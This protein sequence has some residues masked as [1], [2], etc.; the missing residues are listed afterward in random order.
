MKKEFNWREAVKMLDEIGAKCNNKNLAKFLS[1]K[2]GITI[3][4]RHIA[5]FRA[6]ETK[7]VNNA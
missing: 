1:E 2:T 7:R 4:T 6:V 3:T 5:A